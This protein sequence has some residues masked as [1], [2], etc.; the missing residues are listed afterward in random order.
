MMQETFKEIYKQA[1][2]P[3][4]VVFRVG[5]IFWGM[6]GVVMCGFVGVFLFGLRG[7]FVFL[8]WFG[9]SNFFLNQ[10]PKTI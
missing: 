8:L 6:G 5:S 7:L 2:S 4:H 9:F 1:N 10:Q 3:F